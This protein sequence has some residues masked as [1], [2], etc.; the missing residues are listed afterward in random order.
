MPKRLKDF[1]V[2]HRLVHVE[3]TEKMR[4]LAAQ[5]ETHAAQIAALQAEY[6]ALEEVEQ[7]RSWSAYLGQVRDNAIRNLGRA[8][9]R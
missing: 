5:I 1:G 4:A 9:R 2:D 7:R 8:P 3:P 6:A